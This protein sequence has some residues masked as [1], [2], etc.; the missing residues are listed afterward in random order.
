MGVKKGVNLKI[1]GFINEQRL[2][3]RACMCVNLRIGAL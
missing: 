1:G 3:G 2:V